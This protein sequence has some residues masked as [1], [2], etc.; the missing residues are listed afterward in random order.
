MLSAF[1]PGPMPYS[2]GGSREASAMGAEQRSSR[3]TTGGG[4]YA[5]QGTPLLVRA[6]RMLASEEL[7][8]DAI[9]PSAPGA[10]LPRGGS[11]AGAASVVA[12][13]TT[14]LGSRD[15]SQAGAAVVTVPPVVPQVMAEAQEATTAAPAVRSL[16]IA[17]EG[18]DLPLPHGH[19]ALAGRM[20]SAGGMLGYLEAA[21][22]CTATAML[23]LLH[24]LQMM[25]SGGSARRAGGRWASDGSSHAS[26]SSY[27]GI[28]PVYSPPPSQ[29]GS[30]I[31][32][33]HG[34]F[35]TSIGASASQGPASH[36]PSAGGIVH[37]HVPAAVSGPS[38]HLRRA[39]RA[40]SGG[41]RPRAAAAAAS[42]GGGLPPVPKARGGG[43]RVRSLPGAHTAEAHI[44]RAMQLLSAAPSGG[45][46]EPTASPGP[47]EAE[48]AREHE[49]LAEAE[50]VQ[51]LL[52][53]LLASPPSDVAEEE[54][55]E[56]QVEEE[57][58][59]PPA[60]AQQHQEQEADDG[61]GV[62]EE[63]AAEDEVE[64]LA[65][66]AAAAPSLLLLLP[67]AGVA[68]AA[69]CSAA[70]LAGAADVQ[71]EEEQ[72]E[73]ASQAQAPL[74]EVEVEAPHVVASEQRMSTAD[75]LQ[76]VPF[77][78]VGAATSGGWVWGVSPAWRAG[79]SVE[80]GGCCTCTCTQ[81]CLQQQAATHQPLNLP[82]IGCP[83][84]LHGAY[85]LLPPAAIFRPCRA[86]PPP[87]DVMIR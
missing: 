18:G 16:P 31:Q 39:L 2:A 85:V 49:H 6:L 56:E 44:M 38:E 5:A 43:G 28:M 26:G 74:A 36:Q 35:V 86:G 69:A 55:A 58:G 46:G 32:S 8:A 63:D 72:V 82:C 14:P 71:E 27:P 23:E 75:L 24:A 84:G 25:T 29:C 45:G 65:L 20:T 3:N 83:C 51:A 66:D 30:P 11:T 19:A 47:G 48:Q 34:S 4:M 41:G 21:D 37:A 54:E 70:S 10:P 87:D 9:I 64:A 77:H 81:R 1:S 42:A 57:L 15:A 59:A 61:P 52:L 78:Q 60:E 22:P 62:E 67:A 80:R 13:S 79:A 12:A 17:S 40:V 33:L 50:L 76:D 7:P 68:A 73:V 53:L